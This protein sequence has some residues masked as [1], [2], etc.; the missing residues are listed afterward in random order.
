MALYQEGQRVRILQQHPSAP[1]HLWGR[2]G[3]ISFPPLPMR[4][5][6]EQGPG[7]PIEQQC[8]VKFDETGINEMVWESWLEAV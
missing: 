5:V 2:I 3:T 4:S 8:Y 6:S 1:S 7:E